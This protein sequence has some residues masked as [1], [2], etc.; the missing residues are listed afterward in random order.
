MYDARCSLYKLKDMHGGGGGGNIDL[1]ISFGNFF[2][3]N[4]NLFMSI[5]WCE[6]Y[7]IVSL[8]K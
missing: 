5:F 7:R 1:G 2:F 4:Y 8:I 3:S 6:S